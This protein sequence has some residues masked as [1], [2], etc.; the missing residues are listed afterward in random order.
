MTLTAFRAVPVR[1]RGDSISAG[2]PRGLRLRVYLTRAK[3]DRQIATGCPCDSTPTL[4]LRARQLIHH[5]TRSE[6]AGNLRG[7]VDYV[8]RHGHRVV[9]SPVVIERRAVMGGR[10]AIVGLAERLEGTL[11]VQPMGVALALRLLTD[12]A[13][14]L[15]NRSCELTVDE[16]IWEIAEALGAEPPTIEFEA[17]AR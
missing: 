10:E 16:A 8:D 5:H 1:A 13:S 12:G 2:A 14:P 15:F 4:A 11:P 17:A 6:I 9:I 7:V 3:L